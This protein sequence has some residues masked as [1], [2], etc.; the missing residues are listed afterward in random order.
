MSNSPA[1]ERGKRRSATPVPDGTFDSCQPQPTGSRVAVLFSAAA[2]VR[3]QV[4]GP[5]EDYTSG[6]DPFRT[7]CAS[8]PASHRGAR[9]AH[10]VDAGD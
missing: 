9:R 10:R 7:F 3:A 1:V 2:S 4:K 5:A 6:E 8:C